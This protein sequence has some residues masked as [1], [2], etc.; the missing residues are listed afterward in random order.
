MVLALDV[1]RS[2]GEIP[3]ELGR[4]TALQDLQLSRNKLTGKW[5][6]DA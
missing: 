2:A 6:T 4:L 1:L 5:A 3:A